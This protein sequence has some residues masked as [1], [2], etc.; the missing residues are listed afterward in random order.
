MAGHLLFI[1]IRDCA[2]FK[3][4]GNCQIRADYHFQRSDSRWQGNWTQHQSLNRQDN[5]ERYYC[6]THTHTTETLESLIWTEPKAFDSA[7]TAVGAWDC[8]GQ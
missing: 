1:N 7:Q 4:A 3:N 2:V 5:T 6:I 8:V